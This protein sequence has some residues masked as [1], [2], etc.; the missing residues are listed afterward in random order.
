MKKYFLTIGP[1]AILLF[2][3]VTQAS[4]MISPT[5][6][7]FDERQRT[8]KVFLINN[9]SEAK[10]YRLGWKEKQALPAGGYLDLLP[11][12]VGPWKLSHLMRVTPR[13][14]HLEAGERQV[15]KL[16]LRRKQG[17]DDG[18]YRSH[19]LFQALP[20]EKQSQSEAIGVSLN[21][22]LSYSIPVIYRKN[23]SPPEVKITAV[24]LSKNLSGKP[25]I[26][27]DMFRKGAASAFGKLRADWK[28]EGAKQWLNVATAN[29]YAIYP[30]VSQAQVELNI[31]S[32][33]VITGKGQLR[34]TYT[35]QAE[36]RDHAFSQR[37]FDITSQ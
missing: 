3:Q 27:V 34:V 25:V 2:S 20:T 24:E 19:L 14:V 21:M 15:V 35:G 5:R 12:Q 11:N 33:K 36:F 8:A 29:N 18:E 31:L 23:V 16:A 7:I 22:I 1:L 30:E 9:G 28:P 17:M 32:E 4:L 37:T 26:T 10:T 13:Q 6:V